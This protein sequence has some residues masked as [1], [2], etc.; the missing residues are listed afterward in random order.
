MILTR[1]FL[2]TTFLNMFEPYPSHP[3]LL[4]FWNWGTPRQKSIS[5][6][7]LLHFPL[8]TGRYPTFWHQWCCG[9][10]RVEAALV[11]FKCIALPETRLQ[12]VLCFPTF[13]LGESWHPPFTVYINMWIKKLKIGHLQNFKTPQWMFFSRR[14][15]G[16]KF[17]T[18]PV[19]RWFFP[20]TN[21]D[22]L[23]TGFKRWVAMAPS[24]ALPTHLGGQDLRRFGSTD[25]F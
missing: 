10:V 18:S 13:C 16:F 9:K 23:L 3:I 6:H 14:S 1:V 20:A 5:R 21:W 15:Y 12:D 11:A 22:M 24:E 7:F 17:S 8:I 4:C 25:L 2:G 19:E